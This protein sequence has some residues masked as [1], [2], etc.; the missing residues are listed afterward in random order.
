[1]PCYP[2]IGLLLIRLLVGGIFLAH[3][4]HDVFNS[5]LAP[6]IQSFVRWKVPMPLLT[7]PLVATL[8]IVGG[9]LLFLGVGTRFF[10]VIFG[11]MMGIAISYAH[12][13]KDFFADDGM[14]LPLILMVCSF[15]LALS[16]PGI[17]ALENRNLGKSPAP[18]PKP[19]GPPAAAAD[20]KD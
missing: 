16:G 11:L 8:Q 3:G 1:M 12:L 2:S 15:A 17:L 14:E 7:A 13:G 20:K 6:F 18:K 19:S 9:L 4:I 5:D 10:A